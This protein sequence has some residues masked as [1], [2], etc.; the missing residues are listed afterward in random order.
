MAVGE[1][2]EVADAMEPGWQDMQQEAAARVYEAPPKLRLPQ[3]SRRASQNPPDPLCRQPEPIPAE[4]APV[5]SE[6]KSGKVR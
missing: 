5:S 6:V 4:G 1:E 3:T 2:A